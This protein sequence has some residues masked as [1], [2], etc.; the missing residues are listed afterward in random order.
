MITWNLGTPAIGVDSKRGFA[1]FQAPVDSDVSCMT[2]GFAAPTA[3]DK[4][5]ASGVLVVEKSKWRMVALALS[6]PLPDEQLFKGATKPPVAGDPTLDDSA[7]AKG[8]AAWFSKGGLARAKASGDVVASGTAP[9]EYA[10][11]AGAAKLVAA[12]DRLGLR[13]DSI[14][15]TS[16]AGGVVALIRADVPLPVNKKAAPMTLHAIAIVDGKSWRWVSLQFTSELAAPPH[17]ENPDTTGI[18]CPHGKC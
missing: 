16:F 9:G 13:A 15:A 2:P 6:R 8:A 14:D 10:T 12:W 5:R 1:W 4:L 11:G 17:A 7:A 3:H 18:E